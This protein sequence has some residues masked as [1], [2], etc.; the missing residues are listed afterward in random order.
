[1]TNQHPYLNIEV[2]K[3]PDVRRIALIGEADLAGTPDLEAA[4]NEACTS[5]SELTVLDLRELTFIDSSGLH[6][7]IK[8]SQMHRARGCELKIIPGPA[9]LQRLFELTG[10]NDALSFCDAEPAFDN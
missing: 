9:S 6:A 7:L 10:M 4:L 3:L 5:G 2:T 1:M 8:G